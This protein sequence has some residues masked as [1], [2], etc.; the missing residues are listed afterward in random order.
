MITIE[1]G[2]EVAAQE[3]SISTATV[4]TPIGEAELALLASLDTLIT[5]P[6][7]AKRIFN[8]YRM[9]RAT[10][11]LSDASR[12]LGSDGQPG[13][14]QAVVVLLG[15]LTAHPCLLGGVLDARPD[16]RN[17]VEGGLAHRAA[18]SSWRQFVADLEPRWSEPSWRNRVVGSFPE[19][20]LSQWIRL[21]Q[22]VTELAEAVDLPDLTVVQTWLPRVRRF[23]Y[24]LVTAAPLATPR[25]VLPSGGAERG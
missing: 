13:E 10:R 9:I 22:G 8:L 18:D 11:D 24:T 19:S 23:S 12:F 20:H 4:P 25:V 6:R 2:S 16:P 15:L 14:Y 17:D 7:E 3:S 5:T 21:H 1:A